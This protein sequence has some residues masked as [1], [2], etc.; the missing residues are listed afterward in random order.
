MISTF[1]GA[2]ATTQVWQGQNDPVLGGK[3]TGTFKV[4]T[5]E[6]V[7]IFNGTCAVVPFLKAPGFIKTASSG[8]TP[9]VSSCKNLVLNVNSK[10]N[11]KG[12]KVSF[13]NVHYPG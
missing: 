3:S 7:G 1:D 6:Q 2:P 9:D 5:D 11:Y 13:S 8:S 10:T 4:D 12:Y